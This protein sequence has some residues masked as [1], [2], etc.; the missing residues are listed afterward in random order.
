MVKKSYC[1]YSDRYCSRVLLTIS[2][3]GQKIEM[4]TGVSTK[5]S[6]SLPLENHI[7]RP[8]SCYNAFYLYRRKEQ[9]LDFEY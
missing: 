8:V 4:I 2:G 1:E 9:P 6:C 7:C 3:N 5:P